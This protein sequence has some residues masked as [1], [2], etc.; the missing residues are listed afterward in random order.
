MWT[1]CTCPLRA[2]RRPCRHAHRPRSRPWYG[3]P[4]SA[5]I[6]PLS[7]WHRWQ[8]L[9]QAY[10]DSAS[11]LFP[12][13]LVLRLLTAGCCSATAVCWGVAPPSS[14]LLHLLVFLQSLM[15]ALAG[16]VVLGLQ[17]EL[18][19]HFWRGRCVA[20]IVMLTQAD[21]FLL[22]SGTTSCHAATSI[23]SKCKK[24]LL[25]D[26]RPPHRGIPRCSC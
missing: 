3:L 4:S 15:V 24:V 9:W 2:E 11:V 12:V 19:A 20:P 22:S 21:S 6:W 5:V 23:L 7:C 26:Y 8:L 17:M 14:L 13:T 25:V 10:R 18:V 16:M 1:R